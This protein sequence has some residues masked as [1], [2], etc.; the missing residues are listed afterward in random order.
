ML[1]AVDFFYPTLLLFAA[2]GF[3]SVL[4]VR[5]DKHSARWF[6]A[7][8]AAGAMAFVAELFRFAVAKPLL[9]LLSGG[10]F[11][12]MALCFAVGLILRA[13]RKPPMRLF[14]G[15]CLLSTVA[16]CALGMTTI[17]ISVR[18]FIVQLLAGLTLA[19][20]IA[21]SKDRFKTTIDKVVLSLTAVL[22]CF[23]VFTPIITYFTLG[24]P[25]TRAEYDTSILFTAVR[26]T[27]GV[28]SLG[29]AMLL[30]G[31][32]L[33]VMISDL[34]RLADRDKLTGLLNRRGFENRLQTLRATSQTDKKQVALILF[35]LDLFK[36]VNDNFGHG[37]G[38][39]VIKAMADVLNAHRGEEGIAARLG[40]EEFVVALP[41]VTLDEAGIA[42]ELIR[43]RWQR[44]VH[45]AGDEEFGSTVSIGI[46]LN[47]PHEAGVLAT[48]ARA[49]EALYLAK[50]S[51]R[52]NVKTQTDVQVAKLKAAADPEVHKEI[53]RLAQ[54]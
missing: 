23:L 26:F 1:T 53:R 44:R 51:G 2:A 33:G 22:A 5:P 37:V 50:H 6:A 36:S 25:Q 47:M 31:E 12:V 49:D 10:S 39:A 35:D 52:N 45:Y 41:V 8:Y 32:Y 43:E 34:R 29:T 19:I 38:D 28:M 40:G 15:I 20:G 27:V 21:Y 3:R 13:D 7:A 46:A 16:S 17:S 24:L 30:V 54:S 11:S 48:L 42:A 4:R 18:I 9:A 14:F